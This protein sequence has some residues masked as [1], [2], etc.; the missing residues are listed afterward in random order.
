MTLSDDGG[1]I[2]DFARDIEPP[3][4]KPHVAPDIVQ[5][6]I[7]N[8]V[9]ANPDLAHVKDKRELWEQAEDACLPK[10]NTKPVHDGPL[11]FDED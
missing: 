7:F 4:T 2:A 5:N 11:I 10:P 8:M 6:R 3:S 9:D 1:V